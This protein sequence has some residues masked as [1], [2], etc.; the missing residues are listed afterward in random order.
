MV[1]LGIVPA[2]ISPEP[3]QQAG[4]EIPAALDQNHG[5][6]QGKQVE[7][8]TGDTLPKDGSPKG[9]ILHVK[10]NQK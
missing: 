1:V 3:S 9:C 10:F 5:R 8:L 2:L 4:V 6:C 7:S